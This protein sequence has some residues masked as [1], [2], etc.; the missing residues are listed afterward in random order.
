[1]HA[2]VPLGPHADQPGNPHIEVANYGS[3]SPQPVASGGEDHQGPWPVSVTRDATH[4]KLAAALNIDGA[5]VVAA[6]GGYFGDA[7][8]YQG[9][10]ALIDRTS[11]RLRTVYN[12]VEATLTVAAGGSFAG[13][14]ESSGTKARITSAMFGL[15]PGV[16]GRRS[17]FA[18]R[19]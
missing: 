14:A 8:P 7:P 13:V 2:T 1:V 12:T 4:E 16:D 6:T 15:S 10:V 3:R 17:L 19:S 9:H 18:I 5:D 11:G